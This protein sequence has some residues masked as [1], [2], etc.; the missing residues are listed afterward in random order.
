MKQGPLLVDVYRG[1]HVESTHQVEAVVMDVQGKVVESYGDPSRLVFP[2]SSI[3]MPQAL[4]LLESGAA[5]KFALSQKCISL[6]CASH[7]GEKIHTEEVQSWL[8]KI[9]LSVSNF[10]CGSHFPYDEDTKFEMIRNR[11]AATAIHNNCSGKHSG[12]LTTSVHLKENPKGYAKY[13]HPAQVR[14]RQTL[15]E[16]AA[17]NYDQAPWGVDGCGIPTYA[18]PLEKFALTWAAFLDESSASKFSAIRKESLRKILQAVQ[19]EPEMISGTKGLCSRVVQVSQ[20]RAFAKTGAEGVY[21]G[22]VPGQGLAM[23][24]KVVDGGTRAAEL[25]AVHLL[26]KH[27]GLTPEEAQSVKPLT[28]AT[29]KNWAGE[30]VGHM[31]IR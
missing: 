13:D 25:A 31:G 2:R 16:L 6:A 22:L 12:L 10:E 27:K 18:I 14:L 15:G 30:V 4:V 24:L 21:A 3:K 20:G 26:Q 8:Q 28:T 17:I 19:A 5:E 9:G 11:V 23:A 1:D 7:N 29:I